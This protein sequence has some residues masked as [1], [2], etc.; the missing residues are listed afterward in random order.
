MTLT[1]INII[2]KSF[3]LATVASLNSSLFIPEVAAG[4][5]VLNQT[6]ATIEKYFGRYWS[7]LTQTGANGKITVTYW[8]SPARLRRLFPDRAKTTL[9]MIYIDNRVQSIEIQPFKSQNDITNYSTEIDNEVIQNIQ[10]ESR[11]FEA[12]F[13]YRPPIYKPLS[14]E[15]GS[16]YSYTNCLGNG[17]TSSYSLHFSSRLNS[18]SFEYNAACE[19]PYD[20]IEFTEW[21]GPSGG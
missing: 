1:P 6:P 21:K 19:P 2:K 8:Y 9:S 20:K 18:M 7:K 3:I 14:L 15:Y 13:G 10:M 11:Y 17:V 5:Y 12:I 16:F 4:R